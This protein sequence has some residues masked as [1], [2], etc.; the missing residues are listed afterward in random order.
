MIAN[1]NSGKIRNIIGNRIIELNHL[2]IST[3]AFGFILV[4]LVPFYF[5]VL[6]LTQETN[7]ICILI[8]VFVLDQLI[9]KPIYKNKEQITK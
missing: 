8:G 3:V 4:S 2:C 9:I 5:E 6:T 1:I 7:L